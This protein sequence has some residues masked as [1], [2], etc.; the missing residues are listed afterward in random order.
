MFRLNE[1]LLALMAANRS[2][3][4]ELNDAKAQ[5]LV[6]VLVYVGTLMVVGA[7][8]NGLVCYVYYFRFKKT[9]SSYFILWLAI[10]DLITCLVGMPF[11]L[12][13]LLKPYTFDIPIACKIMRFTE[14]VT[15]IASGITLIGVAFDRYY[16]VC[17]PLRRFPNRTAKLLNLGSFT[18]AVTFSWPALLVFGPKV[19]PT[20]DPYVEGLEC[21]VDE[22]VKGGTL[23]ILYYVFLAIVFTVSVTF[24]SILYGLLARTVLQRRKITIGEVLEDVNRKN[25][26]SLRSN[27][28]KDNDS[29]FAGPVK[30]F[31][32]RK[33]LFSREESDESRR[34]SS[35]G[36]RI[37]AGKTTR[38]LFIVS[39][40]F[41]I[42]FLPYVI[43][44]IIQTL[45]KDFSDYPSVAAEVVYNLFVRFTNINNAVNPIIYSFMHK[46]FRKEC[47][48]A[49]RRLLHCEDKNKSLR[50][51]F[52][53]KSPSI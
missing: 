25:S 37:R 52:S 3:R 30:K 19:V 24:L 21:S 32:R 4:Q 34:S 33:R 6:P 35:L 42:S 26:S 11:E 28:D 17:K 20:M 13:D 49:F 47:I 44:K 9:T 27:S 39:S 2:R 51:G 1:T 18:I 40:V 46:N 41:V 43:V 5:Q 45:M 15:I 8:G 29:V 22:G 12:V 16:K 53:R 7:I 10:L 50:R 36:G 14:S 31:P 48:I 38:I 23:V